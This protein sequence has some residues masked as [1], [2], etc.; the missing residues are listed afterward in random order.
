MP[1][2]PST[3]ARH[4]FARGVWRESLELLRALFSALL[5][6]KDMT[7]SPGASRG[8]TL[9]AGL[10]EKTHRTVR[11]RRWVRNFAKFVSYFPHSPE[12]LVVDVVVETFVGMIRFSA[13]G[14]IRKKV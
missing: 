1:V 7:G 14:I 11:F 3:P 13:V 6:S 4:F 10:N 8:A 2:A 9:A 5:L 12:A